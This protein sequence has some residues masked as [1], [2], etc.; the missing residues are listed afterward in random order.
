MSGENEIAGVAFF[1]TG[2]EPAGF[3]IDNVTFGSARQIVDPNVVPEPA[4]YALL[5]TGLL[6][7][8]AF[9][10]MRRREG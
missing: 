8:G 3:A 10:R 9:G 7:L 6:G 4:T 5:G 2:P 1:I